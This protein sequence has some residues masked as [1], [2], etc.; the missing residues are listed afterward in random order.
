MGRKNTTRIVVLLLLFSVCGFGCKPKALM[1]APLPADQL[2][3]ALEKAFRTAPA[4][5]KGL[6]DQVIAS[7]KAQNYAKAHPQL[8]SLAMAPNLNKEQTDVTARGL[9]TLYGLLQSAEAQGD[10]KAAEALQ[11]Y[12]ANK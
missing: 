12:R 6:A 1:P 11:Q 5:V 10:Q 3:A 7:I 4:E 8:Q 2:P 9:L